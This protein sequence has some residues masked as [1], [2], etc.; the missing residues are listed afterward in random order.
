MTKN[1][2]C[3]HFSEENQP[4]CPFPRALGFSGNLEAC[5]S[6]WNCCS[7]VPL[8]LSLGGCVHSMHLKLFTSY[9]RILCLYVYS[10]YSWHLLVIERRK[11]L[12]E[13]CLLSFL[14]PVLGN[15]VVFSHVLLPSGWLQSNDDLMYLTFQTNHRWG[16]L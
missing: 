8:T 6:I 10:D 16:F 15:P 12:V 4:N 14:P 13:S 3:F 2:S 7:T 11:P 9:C 1:F 5:F